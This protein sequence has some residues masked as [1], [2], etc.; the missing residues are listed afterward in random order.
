MNDDKSRDWLVMKKQPGKPLNQTAQ[1][2][3][4]AKDRVQCPQFFKD[5]YFAVFNDAKDYIEK[6]GCAHAGGKSMNERNVLFEY[7]KTDNVL[8][9]YEE[10]DQVLFFPAPAIARVT[11]V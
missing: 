10:P 9:E 2:E 1:Y 5:A 6:Y 7:K 11:E 3:L 4:F 8:F